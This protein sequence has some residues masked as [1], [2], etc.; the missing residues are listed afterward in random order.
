MLVIQIAMGRPPAELVERTLDGY[1][2]T[3]LGKGLFERIAPLDP[4]SRKW[5][6]A[7]GGA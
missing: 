7:V 5:A 3:D 2:L 4:R 1:S 6:K